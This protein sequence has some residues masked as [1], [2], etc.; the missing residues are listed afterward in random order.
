MART[1]RKGRKGRGGRQSS[2]SDE[3]EPSKK[4]RSN[5]RNYDEAI[6]ENEKF[7]NYYKSQNILS[8]S[9][10]KKLMDCCRTP[11]PVSFRITGSRAHASQLNEFMKKNL[12]PKLNDL[13]VDDVVI[14]PPAPIC[15][16]PDGLGYVFDFGR[17]AL[18]RSPEVAEFHRFLVSETEVGNI[19]RQEAVSMIPVLLM[20]VKQKQYVLDMC[21]AP[22]S[23][24]AQLL[25]GVLQETE[26]GE[27]PD[28][29]VIANDMDVKRAYMLVHQAKRLQTPCVLV[30]NHEAQEFPRILIPDSKT[31]SV[32]A[33]QFDR[34][35]CDVPCSGDG[36]IRKNKTVWKTWSVGGGNG[37]HPVQLS[38]LM[39]GCELLKTGGR[40]VYSTCS[41]NPIENEAVVASMLKATGGAMRLVDVSKE[42]KGLIRYPGLTKW[43]VQNKD[44]KQFDEYDQ[45]SGLLSTMFAPEGVESLGLEKCMRIYPFSQNSGG[46]FVAVLEKVTSFGSL[47]KFNQRK[48]GI[49]KK[50]R[51]TE[52]PEVANKK[53][54]AENG[55]K[56]DIM[57]EKDAQTIAVSKPSSGWTGGADSTEKPFIF[58]SEEHPIVKKCCETYGL[59]PSF[60]R[61]LFLIRQE[62]SDD[63]EDNFSNIYVV[64]E[65]AKSVLTAQNANVLKV[66]NTGVSIFR[67]NGG[68]TNLD[69]QF[70]VSSEGVQTIAPYLSKERQ[71]DICLADL[72]TLIKHEYPKFEEFTPNGQETL[73]GLQL[74]NCL[75]RFDSS[76]EASCEGSIEGIITLPLFRAA[77]SASLLLDKPG[78]RS[79]LNRLTLETL[80]EINSGL[81]KNEVDPPIETKDAVSE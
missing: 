45:E 10:F 67:K 58:V 69:C 47:D 59:L 4:I 20:D 50:K 18:R 40:L 11:L 60:P 13:K 79:L 51:D 55:D 17:T 57:S 28:S 53:F 44:G 64:T 23:K 76:K 43:K 37:L 29:L 52:E 15:W 27:F 1:K 21:A 54:K 9:E 56:S 38:I 46:F 26:N 8:E 72:I 33:C 36:T 5:Q 77:V 70:R 78:R 49:D 31:G 65:K 63:K 2:K 12:F 48:D 25:E 80:D 68:K 19:S 74:G 32:R 42:L 71:V 35:L 62:L 16:Y 14:Q 34:I 3:N 75:V 66:V 41:L 39:R 6:M 73:K 24:T 30:T 61:D 81:S 7:E 22:G